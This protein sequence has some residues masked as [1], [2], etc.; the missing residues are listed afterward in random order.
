[1]GSPLFDALQELVTTTSGRKKPPVIG[2]G[3]ERDFAEGILCERR[4]AAWLRA[5]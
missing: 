2:S 3:E 5:N 1:M 4:A